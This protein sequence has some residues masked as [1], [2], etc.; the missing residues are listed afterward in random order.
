[1]YWRRSWLFFL[2]YQHTTPLWNA[3]R[4]YRMRWLLGLKQLSSG[5]D[6]RAGYSCTFTHTHAMDLLYYAL[7]ALLLLLSGAQRGSAARIRGA[8]GLRGTRALDNPY[9]TACRIT[10]RNA[11]A[12]V[13]DHTLYMTCAFAAALDVRGSRRLLR[14]AVA[15]ARRSAVTDAPFSSLCRCHAYCPCALP[16]CNSAV[17]ARACRNNATGSIPTPCRARVNIA[18]AACRHSPPTA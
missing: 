5:S 7:L 17:L 8:R 18:Q 13:W 6:R 12:G 15:D 3:H 9:I 10:L 11:V 4:A 1:M 2:R 16:Y 14:R